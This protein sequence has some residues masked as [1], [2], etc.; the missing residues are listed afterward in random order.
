ML[1]CLAVVRAGEEVVCDG[2]AVVGEGE[3][4]VGAGEGVE[5]DDVVGEC[6]EGVQDVEVAAGGVGAEAGEEGGD[7][8]VEDGLERADGLQGEEGVEGGAAE[9][10]EGVVDCADPAALGGLSVMGDL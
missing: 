9:F 5:V 2:A 1:D 8:R 10:V 3:E 7:A 6:G 4:V